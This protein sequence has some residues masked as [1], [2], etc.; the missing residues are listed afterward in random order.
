MHSI[1][2]LPIIL[3]LLSLLLLFFVF[4]G[5]RASSMAATRTPCPASY[6]IIGNLIAFLRNRNRFLEWATEMISDSPSGTIKVNLFL[7]NYGVCTANPANVEHLL[8]TNFRN[9]VKGRRFGGVLGDLLGNG[10]FN[11]DGQLW[12][13][14]RKTA[15]CEFSTK[16]LKNFV[17]EI[18]QWEITNRLMPLL[19]DASDRDA[20]IDLQ[21]VLQKFGF[22]NICNLAFGYDPECLVAGKSMPT[23][24]RAFD[25]ATKICTDRFYAPIQFL[26]KIKRVL[27]VGSERKLS[28]AIHTVDE[29]AMKIIMSR[30]EELQTNNGVLFK[31]DLLS[32]FMA[33]S[34]ARDF[35]EPE[36][37]DD[38]KYNLVSHDDQ[39]QRQCSDKFLRDIVISFILA[40][41]DSTS[42]ALTWFFWLLS[43][44]S[45][46][47]RKIY[48]EVLQIA[49]QPEFK[50]RTSG[51][52]VFRYEELKEM[53]YLHAALSEALRLFP[54]VPI[55]S[56]L[57]V[58]E[59][60]LPDGTYVGA[61]WFADYS[62]YAMGRS[63]ELWG[64]NCHEFVP[65]R[66][67]DNGKFV[68]ENQFKFPV[69]HAGPRTCLGKDMA[70][71]Q[72]KSLVA[73]ILY[74]FEIHVAN[75]GP[76]PPPYTLALT[77]KMKE[78][79]TVRVIRRRERTSR[80]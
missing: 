42:S 54:P 14:Q 65:E 31:Q 51:W 3:L 76:N 37:E 49:E 17:M 7:R 30:K 52:A 9:Y 80:D 45:K 13:K 18:V 50:N 58:S 79:L 40:G 44:N 73:S 68:P 16:S 66:W 62:A 67:L 34:K 35:D 72:M 55:D 32:R 10:I 25:Q 70:Y 61:G 19:L 59:D 8:K 60:V 53:H 20:T 28:E 56:R 46:A 41:K 23:F 78:G 75:G 1:F 74:S 69:F 77:M 29:Y 24:A 5:R 26:W 4:H 21:D 12:S 71:I 47:E 2:F 33:D 63:K 27:G 11:V 38:Q 39:D 6:P 36:L 48:N 22:D 15:S 43:V 57:A 64:A